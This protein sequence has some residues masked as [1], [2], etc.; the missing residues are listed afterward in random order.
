MFIAIIAPNFEEEDDGSKEVGDDNAAAGS[1]KRL[2]I[3]YISF[4]AFVWSSFMFIAIPH[5]DL[6]NLLPSEIEPNSELADEVCDFA[7]FL[8]RDFDY[9]FEQLISVDQLP[10]VNVEILFNSLK[11]TF[12]RRRAGSF[13]DFYKKL[14]L[15]HLTVRSDMFY[16]TFFP[17]HSI[18]F[19]DGSEGIVI[20]LCHVQ[21]LKEGFGKP[22][23]PKISDIK[24]LWETSISY[25]TKIRISQ[26]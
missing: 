2:V 14:F 12:G 25:F 10:Q 18:L 8:V 7:N 15:P 19:E 4:Y 22:W 9:I 13:A 23:F 21:V 11:F 5:L 20:S 24:F 17:K 3:N 16:A 26:N 6:K 1:G